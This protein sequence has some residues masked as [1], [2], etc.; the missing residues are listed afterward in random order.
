MAI[1]FEFND[2]KGAFYL[3]E[4]GKRLAEMVFTMAGADKLIIDHTDVDDSLRGQGVGRQ[5]LDQLI[6][7]VRY[8]G[9][10]VIPLCPF[11]KSVFEKDA[12]IR[13]VLLY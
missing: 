11:A 9:L 1:Q 3:E 7:Y 12:S 4:N 13:D 10:K 8:K 2:K 5:L 6:E